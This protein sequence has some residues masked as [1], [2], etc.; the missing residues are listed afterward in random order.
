MESDVGQDDRIVL[1]LFELTQTGIDITPEVFDLQVGTLLKQLHTAAQ[2]GR[3]HHSTCRK[4]SQALIGV[5]EEDIALVLTLG[6]GTQLQSFRDICR[7]I[8]E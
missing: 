1:P 3:P 8:F 7:N 2:R 4:I 6:N 5:G